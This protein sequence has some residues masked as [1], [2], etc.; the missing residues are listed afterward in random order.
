M[1]TGS[2]GETVELNF[3][4]PND[5]LQEIAEDIYHRV[6]LDIKAIRKDTLCDVEQSFSCRFGTYTKDDTV[7]ITEVFDIL[8]EITER[9]TE[10]TNDKN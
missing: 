4:L 5:K 1:P 6:E 2:G 7:K 3:T 8:K 10:G 9:L